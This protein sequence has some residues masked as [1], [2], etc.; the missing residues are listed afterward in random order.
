M[1]VQSQEPGLELVPPETAAT[2]RF[3]CSPISQTPLIPCRPLQSRNHTVHSSSWVAAND[4]QM[5]MRILHWFCLS[6]RY[7]C[8][9]RFLCGLVA[10]ATSSQT[11]AIA[12]RPVPQS[13]TV[14]LQSGSPRVA[15][16]FTDPSHAY[17]QRHPPL[18]HTR[19]PEI[20]RVSASAIAD[21]DRLAPVDLVKTENKPDEKILYRRTV[22]P[23]IL[24]RC[25][26]GASCTRALHSNPPT[27]PTIHNHR[28]GPRVHSRLQSESVDKVLQLHRH[29]QRIDI[30]IHQPSCIRTTACIEH[31]S[32]V[33]HPSCD[34]VSSVSPL[35]PA[36]PLLF[37]STLR[38]NIAHR[39]G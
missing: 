36:T 25:L 2:H 35:A 6:E 26:L 38:P 3:A 20:S 14:M 19:C 34:S 9:A 11:P 22:R 31:P 32:L 12:A 15:L 39:H 7:E 33:V 5:C 28:V 10:S 27:P 17:T 29:S 18:Q 21:K 30:D 13:T 4:L 8:S 37:W 23:G 1:Q 24:P 16:A